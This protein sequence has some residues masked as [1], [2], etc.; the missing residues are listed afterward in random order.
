MFS[1]P[2]DLKACGMLH[3]TSPTLSPRNTGL[4]N[5]GKLFPRNNE[6]NRASTA[7]DKMAALLEEPNHFGSKLSG[8]FLADT[9][10]NTSSSSLTRYDGWLA[11]SLLKIILRAFRMKAGKQNATVPD[12][13]Y[14]VCYGT[15]F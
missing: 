8:V 14:S 15:V 11:D 6:H 3:G 9:V 1:I 4:I 13:C 12:L 10:P 2:T 5:L 7:T